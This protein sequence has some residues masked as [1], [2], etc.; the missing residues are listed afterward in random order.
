MAM[1]QSQSFFYVDPYVVQ[2][3][4]TVMGKR[5]VVE[6]PRGAVRGMLA[7]VKPDHIIVRDEKDA[8]FIIRIAQIILV[9]PT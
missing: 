7:E 1:L 3:L 2:T 9:M 6:T 8:V 4:T 5:V